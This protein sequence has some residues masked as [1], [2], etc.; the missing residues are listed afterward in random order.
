V[1]SALILNGLRHIRRLAFESL[2]EL[3]VRDFSPKAAVTITFDDASVS[4]Y[5]EGLTIASKYD[6]PGTLYV[7][8]R[9]VSHDTTTMGWSGVR[10]FLE[11]GWEIGSHTM[12]HADL[13][14]LNQEALENEL[15]TSRE[16]IADMIGVMPESFAS[17]FGSY[18]QKVLHVIQKYYR[19]HVRGW[20]S[21]YGRHNMLGTTD[22]FAIHRF[23]VRR[24]HT[25]QELCE[26]V[27]TAIRRGV[28][29]VFAFHE[30][31]IYTADS[32]SVDP[33][34]FE[35]LMRHIASRRREEVLAVCRVDEGVT[36]DR[37]IFT[38]HEDL[39]R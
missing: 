5:S 3:R 6:I 26:A 24:F 8:V 37:E 17:P 30:L 2:T 18:N 11:R 10:S 12:S 13:K 1:T 16:C 22:H 36:Y 9:G 25:L 28:W 31:E 35:G 39:H 21:E 38:T 7:P 33:H 29:L 4:Q 19:S 14:K 32:L 27:D 20:G 34:V 15:A 23:N